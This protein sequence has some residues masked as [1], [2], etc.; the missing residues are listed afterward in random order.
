LVK[1]ISAVLIVMLPPAPPA[2]A[3]EDT[4][5]PPEML[6][7]AGAVIATSPP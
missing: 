1:A 5:A 3:F 4:A 2:V 6:T 7:K